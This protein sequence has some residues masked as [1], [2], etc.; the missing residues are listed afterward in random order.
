MEELIALFIPDSCWIWQHFWYGMFFSLGQ[1]HLFN[2]ADPSS[3]I[4]DQVSMLLF[5]TKIEIFGNYSSDKTFSVC[6]IWRSLYNHGR[7]RNLS[8]IYVRK[9][10]SKETIPRYETQWKLFILTQS[11]LLITCALLTR[12]YIS[13]A[14]DSIYKIKASDFP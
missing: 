7:L 5:T 10:P 14:K 12:K 1:N 9:S 11:N 6:N 8:S 3:K 13:F 4:H 2:I